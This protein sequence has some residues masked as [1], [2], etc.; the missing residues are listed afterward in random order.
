MADATV[1][2]VHLRDDGVEVLPRRGRIGMPAGELGGRPQTRERI[3]EPV[4]HRGRHLSDRG[5]LLRLHQLRLGALELRD[6]APEPL[7]H[8][9]E[10]PGQLADLVAAA[11]RDRMVQLA[12]AHDRHGL[13]QLA[14]GPGES[15]RDD[16]GR[17]ESGRERERDDEDERAAL[18]GEDLLQ[19]GVGAADAGLPGAAVDLAVHRGERGEQPSLELALRD[20]VGA[21]PVP[22][23]GHAR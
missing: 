20:A 17:Q 23:L 2:A 15:A 19:P 16:P 10:R 5:E 11:R 6:V 9:S 13:G 14:D 12:L 4:R 8:A 21:L 1:E 22:R 7:G 3:A 18:A